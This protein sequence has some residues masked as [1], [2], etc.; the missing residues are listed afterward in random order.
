MTQLLEK[1]PLGRD[2]GFGALAVIVVAAASVA[3]AVAATPLSAPLKDSLVAKDHSAFYAP[4]M[5]YFLP[6]HR[7]FNMPILPRAQT[8]VL[9]WDSCLKREMSPEADRASPSPPRYSP[10]V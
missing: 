10:S 5:D 7:L 2:I 9:I 8:S 3:G 6:Q 4:Y 1:Q